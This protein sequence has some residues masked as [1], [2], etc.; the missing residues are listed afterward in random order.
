MVITDEV[1]S[2]FLGANWLHDGF[3]SWGLTRWTTLFDVIHGSLIHRRPTNGST[4][5]K[6]QYDQETVVERTSHWCRT[7]DGWRLHILQVRLVLRGRRHS[8]AQDNDAAEVCEG[9]SAGHEV[10]VV[11]GFKFDSGVRILLNHRTCKE[12]LVL[13]APQPTNNSF[14]SD[15]GLKVACWGMDDVG[16]EGSR[17]SESVLAPEGGP[18]PLV[19]QAIS[20]RR[21]HPVVL[22]PGLASSGV[23]TFDLHPG[24][25]LAEY[26]ALWGWD[27]WVVEL[28]G[29]GSSDRCGPDG[30]SEWCVDH[31]LT[32]DLPAVVGAVQRETGAQKVHFI[33]HS[34]GGM[35]LSGALA[36]Q[37]RLAAAIKSGVMVGSSCYLKG[38]WADKLWPPLLTLLTCRGLQVGALFQIRSLISRFLILLEPLD[39]LLLC[40]ANT[41][42]LM[43]CK[44]FKH[45]FNFVPLSLIHQFR[46]TAFTP[47]GL[48]SACGRFSY[49]DPACLRKVTTPILSLCG[50]K[51][52]LCPAAACHYH[53]S[54]FGSPS[55]KYICLGPQGGQRH[56]YGHFDLLMGRHVE[57]EVFPLVNEWLQEHD[58]VDG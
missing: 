6:T 19:G 27:V 25:S 41:C 55:R 39:R 29:N 54:L 2:A 13:V 34:M 20:K 47:Y 35:L 48:T 31:Y 40:P 51:D 28:R 21:C 37:G 33:G 12:A 7:W 38:I 5:E 58:G 53:W 45:C 1:L 10:E 15:D 30:C 36:Q 22:C 24:V 9:A 43:A 49:A 4:D 32:R 57:E 46:S 8:V 52:H 11:K 23:H 17:M 26:L 44:L 42:H 16:V 56:H 18:L 14:L 50:T 3:A